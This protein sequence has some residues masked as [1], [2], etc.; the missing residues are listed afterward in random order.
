MDFKLYSIKITKT[1]LEAKQNLINKVTK[2][3]TEVIVR[4]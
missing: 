1:V 2:K 4:L 3:V